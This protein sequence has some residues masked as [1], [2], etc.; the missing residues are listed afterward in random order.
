MDDCIHRDYCQLCTEVNVFGKYGHV[1]EVRLDLHWLQVWSCHNIWWSPGLSSKWHCEREK[2]VFSQCHFE[3]NQGCR[4]IIRPAARKVQKHGYLSVYRRECQINTHA[5]LLDDVILNS[6][7]LALK[8]TNMT[9]CMEYP[10][11][12]NMHIFH[13]YTQEMTCWLHK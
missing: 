10:L 8:V 13:E 4:G 6:V 1:F 3:D 7:Q 5:A 11:C 2:E 9:V 12:P